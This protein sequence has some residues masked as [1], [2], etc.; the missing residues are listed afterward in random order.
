M[1]LPVEFLDKIKNLLD[2]AEYEDFIK[3]YDLPRFYG[4]RVNTLKISVEEFLKISPFKLEP[5]PWTKD[6]FYY[7]EGENPGKHPYYYAGLYYIQ[8][9][10]AM[11][12]GAVIDA[13]PGENILD[14]CAAPG[15]KT[16][17]IAAGMKGKGLLV[18]ND[19][20]S[21]R[22]KALVK[23]IELCGITNAVVTNDSPQNLSAKFNHFFDKILIDAPCSGEGMF[24]KDEDAAKSWGKYKCDL[25]SGMQRDILGHV[26]GMLKPGGYLVYST[27]TF[28]PEENE[29]M[30][31]AFLESHPDYELFE[32]PK[33]GGIDDGRPQWSDNNSELKK[34][35]RLWPHKIKGEGHFVALLHK[36]DSN[37]KALESFDKTVISGSN[38]VLDSFRIFEKDNLSVSLEDH[39]IVKGSNLY[40]LP[41]KLPDLSGIKV[42]KFGRYIG[43]AAKGRFEPSHSFILSLCKSDLKNVLSFASN[44][45]EVIKY[46]KGETLMTESQKGYIGVLVDGY[47]L[48][49]AKQTGDMLKNLYP[50]GWRKMN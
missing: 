23:N 39:F 14:L 25:C 20:N 12:P 1:K 4:L 50:K 24:R 44:S 49:W 28:S 21:D 13:K 10:S 34:T 47:T 6:G 30:I 46:L 42:A 9:P 43:E 5:I 17:Q 41:V 8:E 37:Y 40:S 32:V 18:A 26:D 29:Q 45:N 48:G 11:L 16:V 27:C 38:D 35:A 36:K 33:T 7:N 19:I 31:A 15:G 2:A 3:S 22:V